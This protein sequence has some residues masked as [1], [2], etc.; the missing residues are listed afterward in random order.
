[1]VELE[2]DA[3][4][5]PSPPRSSRGPWIAVAVLVLLLGVGAVVLLGLDAFYRR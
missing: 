4:I 3:P 5:A 1:M 2:N